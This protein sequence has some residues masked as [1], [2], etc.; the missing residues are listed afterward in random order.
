MT[1]VHNQQ[2]RR[3]LGRCLQGEIK[4]ISRAAPGSSVQHS[5]DWNREKLACA[6]SRKPLWKL[7]QLGN[8]FFQ[9]AFP[10]LCDSRA[11]ACIEVTPGDKDVINCQLRVADCS[12]N[13]LF[14]AVRHRVA[15]AG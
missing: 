8:F 12:D 14:Y 6:F 9:A 4:M 5:A 11:R 7:R 15:A 10:S 3:I 2:G 13:R 1:Q